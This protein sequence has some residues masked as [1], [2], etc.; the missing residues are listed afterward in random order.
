VGYDDDDEPGQELPIVDG[1]VA[2][3]DAGVKSGLGCIRGVF[4]NGGSGGLGDARTWDCESLLGDALSEGV[5]DNRLAPSALSNNGS[6]GP[7]FNSPVRTRKS[8]IR[9]V[10]FTS[11]LTKSLASRLRSFPP[12][13]EYSRTR[14]SLIAR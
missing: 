10:L 1:R 13:R 6:A 8:H 9:L 11:I 4:V 7:T 3:D 12:L 5:A 2:C 14:V